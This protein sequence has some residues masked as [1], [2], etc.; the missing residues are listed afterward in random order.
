V[1]YAE[2][3]VKL[4]EPDECL[5]FSEKHIVLDDCTKVVV[6]E[7]IEAFYSNL[8]LLLV[9]LATFERL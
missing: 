5:S 6:L 8:V 7:V 1:R 9:V 2:D 3:C 4:S